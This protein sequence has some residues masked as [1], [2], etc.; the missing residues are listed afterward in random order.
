MKSFCVVVYAFA[1]CVLLA[2]TGTVDGVGAGSSSGAGNNITSNGNGSGTSSQPSPDSY[3][4]DQLPPRPEP[5]SCAIADGAFC[6]TFENPQAGGRGGDMNEQLWAVS[7][8]GHDVGSWFTR[9]LASTEGGYDFPAT[10]CGQSFSDVAVG[11]DFGICDGEDSAGVLSQQ[12][13]EVLHDTGDFGINSMMIR[14]PFD[15]ADRTGVISFD[16]DAKLNPNNDGHGW[17]VEMWITEDPEP[18]PYHGA[19]SVYSFPRNGVGFAFEGTNCNKSN[20]ENSLT[21]VFVSRDGDILHEYGQYDFDSTE[22]FLT[23]DS[24]LN[25]M[26]VHINQDSAEV[27]ASD[28]DDPSSFRRI[29]VVNNLDLNFTRGFV[30]FQHSHYNAAKAQGTPSQ[31]FR[32]DN[33]G[34]DGPS[35]PLVRAYDVADNIQASGNT[36]KWGRS[37][38]SSQAVSVSLQNVDLDSVTSALFDFTWM[39]PSTGMDYRING[40]SWHRYDDSNPSGGYEIRAFSV[41]LDL[42]ELQSGSNTIEIKSLNENGGPQIAN[43]DLTLRY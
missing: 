31:V 35:L 11:E 22:C 1:S 21:R 40:G 4:P 32:W 9:R 12:L 33:I 34:F 18:V 25:H 16:V 36:V 27:W 17:W 7:R 15:F 19:P 29:A 10:F 3:R 42:A 38:S 28:Y 24:V 20:W 43:M 2:C 30:A 41:P 5:G 13:N 37:L 26:E 14:Q 39:N 23:H 8:W 6:E